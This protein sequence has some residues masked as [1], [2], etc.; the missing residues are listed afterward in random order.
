MM[1]NESL[2]LRPYQ[3][4]GLE[5]IREHYS[6]GEK[7]VLLHL[8]TGAGKTL[9]FSVMLKKVHEKDRKALLVVRG[10]ALVDQA[11]QRL[12]REG[13]PHGV[14]MANHWN[15]RPKERIQVCSIDTITRRGM[16]LEA[17]MIVI[18]EAHMAASLSY[19]KLIN[20]YPDA[21][22]LSVTATPYLK[23]GLRH[24]ADHVVYP[25]SIEDL[26]ANGY[27]VAPR[28]F[29]FPTDVDL[30]DVEIDKKTGDYNQIQLG[31]AVNK[32]LTLCGDI[33]KHWFSHARDRPTIAFAVNVKHS[34][35]I[36]N[37]FKDAGVCAEHMDADTPE[38]E[39]R[40]ILEGLRAGKIKVVSNVG[41]LCTGVDIP[42]VTALIMA[43]PTKSK[44]LW[45]QQVGRGTRIYPDKKNFIVLDHASNVMQHGPIEDEE[46]CNLDGHGKPPKPKGTMIKCPK[47][48]CTIDKKQYGL[49]CPGTVINDLGDEEL[50]DYNFQEDDIKDDYNVKAPILTSDNS[51]IL[52]EITNTKE[53]FSSR[54]RQDLDKLISIA[55]EK[56]YK[57]GYVWHRIKD[58]HGLSKANSC[59]G[60]I[61][62]RLGVFDK[63]KSDEVTKAFE[64]AIENRL[65]RKT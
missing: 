18:D 51:K 20:Q 50:C 24:L 53:F 36:A 49:K 57:P 17:D 28:Y 55:I 7:R 9:L 43:R 56:N 3:S 16:K 13:V 48:F 32:S 10:R 61:H 29:S 44:N 23:S 35:S 46:P 60:E 54:L 65:C 15:Y 47:C 37:Q 41:I 26:I 8:A 12:F 22:F 45:I 64:K 14:V 19:R 52:V 25:I 6:R 34:K 40:W 5:E 62:R 42:E 59:R 33:V 27:L 4:K 21:Y 31:A 63:L 11:S 38:D 39:R 2:I 1:K 30:G 58:T